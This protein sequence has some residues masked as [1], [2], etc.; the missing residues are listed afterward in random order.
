MRTGITRSALPALV[1]TMG[2]FAYCG[3]GTISMVLNPTPVNASTEVTGAN[4]SA[5]TGASNAKGPKQPA[6]TPAAKFAD[7]PRKAQIKALDQQIQSLR[8][9]FKSQAGPL[10]AQLKSLREKFGTDL[11]SLEA[12]RTALVEQGEAPSIKALNDEEAAQLAALADREN[13]E[14]KKIHERYSEERKTIEQTFRQRR[15]DLETRKK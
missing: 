15:H 2:V 8:D 13:A 11:K 6:D 5:R 1:V 14:I 12:Q 9:Q 10:E 7:D 4:P 3:A